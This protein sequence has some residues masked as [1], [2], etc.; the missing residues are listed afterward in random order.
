VR[1]ECERR[2]VCVCVCLIRYT[3]EAK[4]ISIYG[5]RPLNLGGWETM[6]V[7]QASIQIRGKRAPEVCRRVE[8][9]IDY[10]IGGGGG[11]VIIETE[12]NELGKISC[13]LI[14]GAG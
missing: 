10:G 4:I 13:V 8:S 12:A 3:T 9:M 6:H 5:C 14:R 1:S 7:V 2:S 11:R